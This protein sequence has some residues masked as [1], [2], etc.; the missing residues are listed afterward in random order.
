[1]KADEF[2]K[3]RALEASHWWFQGRRALLRSLV[4]R[5]GLKGALIL[6]AGC[7]TGFA[8]E[9]LSAGGIVIG[10]DAAAE[11]LSPG[12]ESACIARVE[13]V[14]FADEVFDL[15]VA[16]DLL[17]HLEEDERALKEMYRV[18]KPDGYLLVTV[19]ACRWIWSRHDE[20]LGHRRRY[21]AGELADKL[22]A[23]GF[24]VCRCSY[25][26]SSV[27]PIAIFYRL[28]RRMRAGYAAAS[29]LSPVREPMNCLLGAL[30]RL[31]SRLMWHLRLPFGLTVVALARKGKKC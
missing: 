1:M 27:F 13:S 12:L 25:L 28:I 29:D 20:V 15:I 7:G 9:E 21:W 10:L 30:M 14:P 18:C 23:A 17:E 24:G 16:L 22:G 5:L 3:M 11:A 2:A 26:V 6:D 19:P 31:E 8:A 4:R